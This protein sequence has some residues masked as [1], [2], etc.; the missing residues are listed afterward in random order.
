M[1][2]SALARKPS[3][4]TVDR[5]RTTSCNA[6]S[7]R[8][9]NASPTC[10]GGSRS[11]L[12][13]GVLINYIDRER[14]RSPEAAPRRVRAGPEQFGYP[15]QR[16]LRGVRVLADPDRL[17]PRPLRRHGHLAD[18]RVSVEH[19]RG[20]DRDRARLR[21]DRRAR[22]CSSG[23]PRPRRSRP[24]RRRSATGSRAPSAASRPRC[25]TRR[26]NFR[27]RSA[28][29]FTA[30]LLVWFGWRGMF[31]STAALSLVFFA[32]F[33]IFYRNPSEDK[34][35]THAEAQYIRE[36]GGE[37]ET[38]QGERP[39]GA[40]L[41]YLLS[42]RKVWGLTIGFA[43]YGYLFA[44]LLTWLP[45][46]L[47]STFGIN[48]IKAGAYVFLIWGVGT[49]TDL[50]VG[51]WLVDYLIKRGADA[52]RVRKTVLDRRAAD[53]LRRHRR[54]VHQGHQRRGRVD[55]D[56]GRRDLVP[57]AGR[58]VDPRADRAEQ[59]HGSSRRDHELP[60]QCHRLLRADDHRHHRRSA[61]ARSTP[62]SITAAVDPARR[63]LLVRRHPRAASTR[64]PNR[65][66][67]R[68]AAAD[69]RRR[70]RDRPRHVA[71]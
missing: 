43:A 32:L 52:N 27:T 45:T 56:R 14:S 44:F 59:Q 41:A 48:I 54:G 2:L 50:I 20:A 38:P 3:M 71:R 24:T 5:G 58:L 51:G 33:Y 4:A 19:R 62:R 25:S 39:R 8:R 26:R 22:G 42:Q 28:S 13:F 63:H 69:R 66:Q 9:R 46:Y 21:D 35:L 17:R 30:Y 67:R 70:R 15:Q 49:I 47:Q 11:I 36:G 55:H 31:W 65:R 18:R 16:V 23:W 7:S 53:G 60:Q 6:A 37:P 40:S 12:G 68:V 61:P 64:S 10:A 34:R 29:P 57:R 1:F